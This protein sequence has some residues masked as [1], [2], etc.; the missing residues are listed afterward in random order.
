MSCTVGASPDTPDVSPK[1]AANAIEVDVAEEIEVEP[2]NNLPDIFEEVGPDKVVTSPLEDAIL[3]RAMKCDR[4][5]NPDRNLLRDMLIYERDYGVPDSMRGMVLAAAC[6]ESGFNVDAKGDHKCAE[7]KRVS[8]VRFRCDDGKWSKRKSI[9][10]L[11][12]RAWWERKSGYNIDRHDPR[13]AAQA[14]VA[15][16]HQQIEKVRE[17]CGLTRNHQQEQLWRVAWVTA[18]YAPKRQHRCYFGNREHRHF[19]RLK[20]WRKSWQHLLTTPEQ[21]ATR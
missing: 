21:V 14:W 19:K 15:H 20:E 2:V 12:Q 3:D 9:G 10:I 13:Q 6:H 7:E 4:S 8:T 18:V 1:I 16:V 5:R 11:Q 17:P